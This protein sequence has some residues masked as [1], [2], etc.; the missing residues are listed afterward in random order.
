MNGKDAKFSYTPRIRFDPF[1]YLH[2]ETIYKRKSEKLM[3]VNYEGLEY[4]KVKNYEGLEYFKEKNCEGLEYL[5]IFAA[6]L[7]L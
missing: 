6:N 2:V 3:K 7:D 4:F 5:F 1:F